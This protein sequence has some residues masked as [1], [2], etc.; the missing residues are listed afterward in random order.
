MSVTPP[1]QPSIEDLAEEF[2]ARRRRDERPTLEEYT[3]RHPGLAD[4]IHE[5]FPVLGLVEDF[6]PSTGDVSGSIA[7]SIIPG[8]GTLHERLGDFRLL[9][10]VGR[11]GMGV[12][13]EAEQESL[14][15]RVA[16]KV[17]RTNRLNDPKIL[18]RFHRE[19]KAA[20]RLHHTNIVPVFGVGEH[21][22]V[23]FYVMQFIRGLPLD[24][25]LD[26]VRRFRKV[27]P[28]NGGGENGARAYS[29]AAGDPETADLAQSLA[30]D[31][32]V[33]VPPTEPSPLSVNETPQSSDAASFSVTLLD[34]SGFSAVSDSALRYAR[35][36]ARVGLQVAGALHYAHQ[37]GILHRDIKPSN[38]L[39][40]AH[41]TIWVTDFGLAK[42]ASDS[43]L[44]RTGDVVGTIRYMAPERFEGRCDA[45]ADIY[46][47]GLT[48]YELLALRPA[49][50]AADRHSLIRQ[51]TQEE[52]RGL[53]QVDPMVPR[54]LDTIVHRAI[55]KEP[56]DRYA[57]AADLRDELERFL[58]DLPIRSRPVSAFERYWRWCKRNPPLALAS[59]A[60]CA[61]VIAIAVVSSVSAYRN[62][63]LA[64]QLE[65]QRD[66][67][68]HNLIHAYAN[69]A[70]ARRHVRR[71]GQRF[72]ALDAIARAM[73]LAESTGLSE[74]ERFQL[75]NE[76]IAAM[77]LPDM[78]V[79]WEVEL[80][81]PAGHGFT[82]DHDF[83]R[84][85][86]K[87]DDGTVVVRRIA[88]HRILLELPGRPNRDSLRA[89]GAMIAEFSPDGRYL[90]M[91]PTNDRDALQ[92]WDLELRRSV[93]TAANY[94]SGT[95]QAWAFH[96]DGRRFVFGR[97]DGSIV[98]FDLVDGRE[99]KQW[100]KGLGAAT[101]IAF[102]RDGSRIAL[103]F[104]SSGSV[105]VMATDTEH[106]IAQLV[107]PAQVF[108]VAWNPRLPN[109]L[110]AGVEDCTIRVWD[111]E[112]GRQ[113][114]TLA[115]DEK[116][117]L[118]V[119]F[120]P[121][122]ELL[123]SRGWSG[124]LRLWDIRTE[125]QVLRMPSSW[126]PELHFSRDG[127]RLSAHAPLGRAGI[128]DISYQTECRSL[129]PEPASS[130]KGTYMLAIDRA[131][132]HLVADCDNAT[133]LLDVASG[134]ALA[135]LPIGGR[136]VG[137]TVRTVHFDPAGSILTSYPMTLRWPISSSPPGLTIGPPELLQWYRSGSAFSSSR[138]GRLV[139]LAN[140]DGGGLVFDPDRPANSRRI[141]PDRD[142]RQV[143]VSP[144]G[145][146]I[147]TLS[148][149]YGT[150]KVWDARTGRM[151]RDFPENP[152][153]HT[154]L[155][156]PDSRSLAILVHDR[157]WEL[158]ETETWTSRSLIKGGADRSA[159]AFSPD[160][161]IFAHETHFD[162]HEGSIALVELASGRELAWIDD[163][164]G[165]MSSQIMFSPDGTQLFATFRDQPYIRIWDLR[166][167][168]N[169]LAE[170][171]LDWS[172]TPALKSA[173]PPTGEFDRPMP[174]KYRVD[175]GQL[176]LWIKQAPIKRRQQ[177]IED[178]EARLKLEPT[179][180]EVRQWL[181]QCCNA[182][183][184][185][186]VAGSN[187][188]R[189]L[190]R[191]EP[192]ARRAVALAPENDNF[193]KTLG[194]ILYRADHALE[195]VSVLER[196]LA[197]NNGTSFPY[198]LLFL[199]LCHAKMGDSAQARAYF[200][201]AVAWLDTN[202]KFEHPANDELKLFRAE[203]EAVLR[204]SFG[205]LPDDVF[206]KV[207]Q[208]N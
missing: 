24:T 190:A 164:D 82:V 169:R 101:S 130:S 181:A 168:R 43:D 100:T 205:D 123:A 88:D 112:T 20:A 50:G 201:R 45:R 107:N 115:G 87:R 97:T 171:N 51:V 61:L 44:T 194:L 200:D 76:T 60:A 98:F 11:G 204:S 95:A 28:R 189:D 19:A 138:N 106:E 137:G 150:L 113:T 129:V 62:G 79:G 206:A 192:L 188:D 77:G 176:D 175:R 128:L 103:V 183:A 7:G 48:L 198:D 172:S 160:S 35:S 153:H 1:N 83:E 208:P 187:A 199:A 186:L 144:D 146:W 84:Y 147:V 165:G 203:A 15:R 197:V 145:R 185:E 149:S 121:G 110:A 70:E 118:V 75:R 148:H 127:S 30:T 42:V 23:H 41:G 120:H 159:A 26:E 139:A 141:L 54:D 58:A 13:Y 71:A 178:A 32:F 193:L 73:R 57:A 111:V 156:S 31:R 180:A 131:G 134:T 86:S 6:K 108:H 166:A 109:L 195:A 29:A 105:N 140:Y 177:A 96:P 182:L 151:V 72:E 12:V 91:K 102:D 55:A 114:A 104:V 122:G 5:F 119:A 133:I 81:D 173:I 68:N 10:E 161:T 116:N 59:S 33:V 99:L 34:Q 126:L 27:E 142:V 158:I 38:I 191:A 184:W 36:V 143:D 40:D 92:V 89:R 78:R 202:S 18:I 85:A 49:F 132:R 179:Q 80:A 94:S 117:G 47:L 93:L 17:L 37:H 157:G 162:R 174:P 125:R 163:P 39:L 63:R 69:E 4:E 14:G 74:S 90:A 64:N 9:R 3:A 207:P 170:L 8:T 46:S 66:E 65:A 167:V 154:A 56:K 21:E 136:T 155:F 135:K 124:V 22:G 16:L 25:V 196:A 52:P 2:I 53:R 152:S 67:A